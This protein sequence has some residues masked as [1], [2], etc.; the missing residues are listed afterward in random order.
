METSDKSANAGKTRNERFSVFAICLLFAVLIWILIKLSEEHTSTIE[1]PIEYSGF[2]TNK[3]MVDKSD[4]TITLTVKSHGFKLISVK[5]FQKRSPIIVDFNKLKLKKKSEHCYSS[6]IVTSQIL[7]KISSQL[8]YSTELLSISPD[9]LFIELEDLVQKKL[10]VK[11]KLNVKFAKQHHLYTPIKYSPDS[12]I[13]S[14][15]FSV[16][17]KLKYLQTETLKLENLKDDKSLEL[18]IQNPLNNSILS[19]SHT[20]VKVEL[21][22]EEFTEANFDIA[23]N[24]VSG[25]EDLRIK[26][27]PEKVNVVFMVA[28]K[29]YKKINKT[30]FLAV[31]NCDDISIEENNRLKVMLTEFP[32]NVKISR[33]EPEAVEYIILK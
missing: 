5:Y 13:V 14:G 16:I 9:T 11:P 19:L 8:K 25:K 26:T 10:A 3:V 15:P 27:F 1:Y 2:S 23:L 17:S 4:S 31:V 7:S 12:V 20:K 18:K 28:L 33:I 21:D 24:Y 32:E 6:Y 30:M 22:V 29:D